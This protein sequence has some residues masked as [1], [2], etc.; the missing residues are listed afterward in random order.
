[1]RKRSIYGFGVHS[2]VEFIVIDRGGMIVQTGLFRP[3]RVVFCSD[4]CWM[5]EMAAGSVQPL[6]GV[7]VAADRLATWSEP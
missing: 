2:S 7:S 6:V 1:M 4:S 5:A 3:R